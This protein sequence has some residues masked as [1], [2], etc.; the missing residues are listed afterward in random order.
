MLSDA[1][2]VFRNEAWDIM[3]SVIRAELRHKAHYVTLCWILLQ[4]MIPSAKTI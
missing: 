4:S 2:A 3:L 1:Y